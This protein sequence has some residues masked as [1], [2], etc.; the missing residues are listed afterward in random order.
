MNSCKL[1]AVYNIHNNRMV[2]VNEKDKYRV[3]RQ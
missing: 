2:T 3:Y 1:V